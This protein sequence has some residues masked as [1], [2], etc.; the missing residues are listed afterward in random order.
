MILCPISTFAACVSWQYTVLFLQEAPEMYNSCNYTSCEISPVFAEQQHQRI[1][2][3]HGHEKQF[4]IQIRDAADRTTWGKC[5]VQH[6]F[7]LGME[8]LDNC[9]HDK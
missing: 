4:S 3:N 1:A 6:C 5:S 9:A 8:V 2:E 7:F